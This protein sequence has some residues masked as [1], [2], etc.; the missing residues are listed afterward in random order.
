MATYCALERLHNKGEG[1]FITKS[2]FSKGRWN[3]KFSP[4]L[5]IYINKSKPSAKISGNFS[6]KLIKA[7]RASLRAGRAQLMEQK[8]ALCR[9]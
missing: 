7:R 3:V 8:A 2:V 1:G 6:V 4:E 5:V 9:S